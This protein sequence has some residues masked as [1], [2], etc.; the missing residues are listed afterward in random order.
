MLRLNNSRKSLTT[1]VFYLAATVGFRLFRYGGPNHRTPA[2]PFRRRLR[3]EHRLDPRFCRHDG[4]GRNCIGAFPAH[5]P[6]SGAGIPAGRRHRRALHFCRHQLLVPLRSFEGPVHNLQ[7]IH[8]CW[9][10]W[11]WSCSC[12]VSAW[13]LA[14]TASG[15]WV[16]RHH[17]WPGGNGPPCSPLASSWLT[18]WGGRRWN[19]FSWGRPSPSAVRQS[20]SRCC[21]I[22][23]VCSTMR[24]RLIIGI[25]L[26]EDFVAVI[27]LTVLSGVAT[28]GQRRRWRHRGSGNETGNI[29]RCHPDHR[30]PAGSPV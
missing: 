6:A 14:G 3:G 1:Q 29:R 9:Q 4:S 30:R 5:P 7:T 8:L 23:T 15:S 26:V 11:A 20:L 12:L 27:L 19:A 17:Y 16:P 28:T 24:G 2:F 13:K 10:T 22:Q 18:C 21:G 25:L